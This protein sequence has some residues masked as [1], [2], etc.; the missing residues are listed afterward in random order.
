LIEPG[1]LSRFAAA[2]PSLSGALLGMGLLFMCNAVLL[3]VVN[4]LVS[5]GLNPWALSGH[6][7]QIGRIFTPAFTLVLVIKVCAFAFITALFPLVSYVNECVRQAHNS[8]MQLRV[9]VRVVLALMLV[10]TLAFLAW[11]A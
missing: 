8:D 3:L 10:D 6:A 5:Y 9:L 2:L 4:H 7:T 1:H 11:Y